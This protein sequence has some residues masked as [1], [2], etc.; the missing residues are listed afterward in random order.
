LTL[1][2]L[3]QAEGANERRARRG[4]GGTKLLETV[5]EDT[6]EVEEQRKEEE[7]PIAVPEPSPAPAVEAP[8]PA[9]KVTRAKR[10]KKTKADPVEKPVEEP[11]SVPKEPAQDDGK[12]CPLSLITALFYQLINHYN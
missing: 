5:T 9:A 2:F 4:R 12:C 11:V 8:K 3:L 6:G 7:E 1:F 10:G